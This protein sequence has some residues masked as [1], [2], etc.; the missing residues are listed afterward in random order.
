MGEEG[1]EH[2]KSCNQ[3]EIRDKKPGPSRVRKTSEPVK[4]V[5]GT[6]WLKLWLELVVNQLKGKSSKLP[7]QLFI[8]FVAIY[9]Y[10]IVNIEIHQLGYGKN[11]QINPVFSNVSFF[12]ED[13]VWITI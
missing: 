7:S 3:D 6:Q 13:S 1:V 2:S 9:I 5:C 4:R 11:W 10:S 12:F 8:I